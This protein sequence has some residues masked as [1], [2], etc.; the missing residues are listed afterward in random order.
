MRAPAQGPLAAG[1]SI[2]AAWRDRRAS[3]ARL[4]EQDPGEARLLAIAMAAGA[5][6]FATNVAVFAIQGGFRALG[7]E[8]VATRIAEFAAGAFIYHT[9][10]LYLIAALGGLVARACGGRGPY[11]LS[12][13]AMFWGRLTAAP[14]M[15]IAGL[16]SALLAPHAPLLA[17]L[18]QS[19]GPVALAWTL[20]GCYAEAYGFRQTWKV[21]GV[22]T[23]LVLGILLTLR[24]LTLA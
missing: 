13:A 5:T 21:L 22:I 20:S 14:V 19:V 6:L 16:A 24:L 11:R 10:G 1:L 2:F 4:L 12:R 15:V 9:L 3:M 23:G 18:M 17:K 7:E 8:A